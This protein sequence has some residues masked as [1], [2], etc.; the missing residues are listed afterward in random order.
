VIAAGAGLLIAIIAFSR[1]YLGAQW[2]S[3]VAGGWALAL[4][5]VALAGGAYVWHRPPA[6]PPLPLLLVVGV[7]LLAAG[8]LHLARQYPHD[9]ARYALQHEVRT[10]SAVEWWSGGWH[11]LPAW[12][13]DF[14]GEREEPLT[15]QWAGALAPL[16]QHLQT[17]GWRA[18]APWSLY[19]LLTWLAPHVEPAALP[20]LPQLQNGHAPALTL[21]RMPAHA[22]GTRLVLRLWATGLVL[23]D[24]AHTAQPLFVGTVVEER[25][26]RRYGVLTLSIERQDFDAPRTA[27]A[28]ALPGAQAAQRPTASTT[29]RWDG[30][31]LLAAQPSA[32]ATRAP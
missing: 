31:V 28:A 32:M 6:L 15:V 8:S 11:S 22:P 10:L 23:V 4:A 7:T 21:I 18:P 27:L 13:V 9:L 19:G 17:S 16:A 25:L 14:A 30:Q 26:F 29:P 24:T 5:W 20:V 12:R 3:D 2:L 1:L